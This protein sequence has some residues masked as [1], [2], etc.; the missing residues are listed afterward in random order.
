[1]SP[2]ERYARA[3]ALFHEARNLPGPERGS[4]IDSACA[5]DGDLKRLV[6]TLLENDGPTA[7][8]SAEFESGA[9]MELLARDLMQDAA[10][11]QSD[12]PP[13]TSIP[14]Y[15]IIS[16]LGQGGMGAVYQ[17]QQEHPQRM[18]ALKVIRKECL[19]PQVLR[20]FENE[21]YALGQLQHPGIAHI[22][23]SA[24]LDIDGGKQPYF[25]MELIAGEPITVHA[26]AAELS[27]RQRL[28]LVARV[29]DAVNHAHQK[30]VIHRD[31]KPANILVVQSGT[32][33]PDRSGSG[34]DPHD[35]IGQPKV[36]DFGIA[37][38]TDTDAQAL[39]MQTQAGQL[40]GT[41]AYMSPEQ[42]EG[43]ARS[44]DTRSDV[45]A[46]GVLLFQLLA[47]R[48]PLDLSG[49]SAPEAARIIRDEDPT[50][51]EKV[52]PALRGDTSTIVAKAMAKDP[53][54]RYAS[55]AELAADLRRCVNDEPIM[56][57]P[58]TTRYLLGKF[59]RRNK[60]LVAG[61][62]AALC[63]LLIGLAVTGYSLL[64]MHR[65]RA[66]ALDART[67]SDELLK[68]FLGVM[69]SAS[70]NQM[71]KSVTV[72]EAIR[73]AADSIGDRFDDRPLVAAKIHHNICHLLTALGEHDRAI[74]E[75]QIAVRILE[76]HGATDTEDYPVALAKLA[77]ANIIAGNFEQGAALYQRAYDS[78]V[79][80][81]GPR[82]PETL[83][84]AVLLA[85]N[86]M[87]PQGRTEEARR[88][89]EDALAAG[90]EVAPETRKHAELSL[91]RILMN[92]H[93]YDAC[94]RLLLVLDARLRAESDESVMGPV[95]SRLA[96]LYQATGRYDEA[97]K[98][99]KEA[100]SITEN[101][102][103]PGSG[104]LLVVLSSTGE[105]LR[106]ADRL[107]ESLATH[108]EAEALANEHLP[109]EHPLHAI[110]AKERAKALIDLGRYDEAEQDL[111][112][113]YKALT[114]IGAN[115]TYMQEVVTV[116]VALYERTD[117]P[118]R[119][120]QWKQR[121]N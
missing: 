40:V 118:E 8:S 51:L 26:E 16:V 21:A 30:G 88:L 20:R 117:R 62:A 1:V 107:D 53:D 50:P 110:L 85:D 115:P 90:D 34:S 72:V 11:A 106:L 23:E 69:S 3:V 52:R 74:K 39:T 33:S 59:A 17:A 9:G 54:R 5:E 31:L 99:L 57:R 84:N 46:L 70:A 2:K 114:S 112:G 78:A 103:E 64:E 77:H 38:F 18:V 93:E 55:A 98:R 94:E 15:K 100:R 13:A 48:L 76:S 37:R 81:L 116:I 43:D 71:G 25:T 108:S 87:V 45:Y 58:P 104:Q 29:C 95:D 10:P 111:L 42:V 66:E 24:Q 113:A 28:E 27:V 75:G 97:L 7:G 12:Q 80:V 105:T 79:A 36:L 102:F 22:Y 73:A 92:N 60:G 65:Q 91:A 109:P 4:L 86:V 44:L 83:T 120:A 56:A 61:L 41:L 121:L 89:L 35:M 47:G 101:L 14:G 19:S 32:V 49:C 119:A 68:Y 67:A 63:F 6:A 82:H 96:S